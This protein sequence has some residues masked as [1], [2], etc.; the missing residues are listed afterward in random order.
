MLLFIVL[1]V[2]FKYRNMVMS[3][4]VSFCA[5]FFTN[6]ALGELWDCTESVS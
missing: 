1:L 5:V 3:L 2:I 4:M 6:D